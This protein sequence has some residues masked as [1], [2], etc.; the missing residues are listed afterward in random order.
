M[1]SAYKAYQI[2]CINKDIFRY[3]PFVVS[4]IIETKVQI[5]PTVGFVWFTLPSV[6]TP[7][8]VAAETVAAVAD[9]NIADKP[10]VF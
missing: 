5:F 4:S 7:A 10:D 2:Y 1:H 9:A 3:H 6:K 8:A